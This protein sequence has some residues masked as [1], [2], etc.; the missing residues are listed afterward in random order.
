[1]RQLLTLVQSPQVLVGDQECGVITYVADQAMYE[2]DCGGMAG[3]SVK[4]TLTGNPLTLCE[5][6][7]Y[8]ELEDNGR[9]IFYSFIH[10]G[11]L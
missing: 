9:T 1:M 5:V 2:L 3:D 4:V 11:I 7:V 10:L 6:Q 8:G